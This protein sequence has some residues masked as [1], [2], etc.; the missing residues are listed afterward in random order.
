MDLGGADCGGEGGGGTFCHGLVA[1]N[2][3][4]GDLRRGV[5]LNINSGAG[6]GIGPTAS[7][8]WEVGMRY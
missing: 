2:T 8:S 5:V 6:R 7:E 3:I 1:R 4:R